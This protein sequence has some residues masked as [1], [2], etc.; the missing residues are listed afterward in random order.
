MP[1]LKKSLLKL[2]YYL[3][4]IEIHFFTT[5][6]IT[7]SMASKSNSG[8]CNL[9]S[10]VFLSTLNLMFLPDSKREAFFNS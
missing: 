6:T 3:L 10:P 9:I 7:W 4:K 1:Y 8:I 5:K 2:V